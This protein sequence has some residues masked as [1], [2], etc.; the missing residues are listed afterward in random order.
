M[1]TEFDQILQWLWPFAVIKIL[2]Q[3]KSSEWWVEFDHSLHKFLQTYNRVMALDYCQNFVSAQNRVNGLMA[4]DH[5]LHM[6]LPQPDVGW[7]YHVSM[8]Q[9]PS[10]RPK[11][12]KHKQTFDNNQGP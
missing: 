8:R 5:I 2:F 3:L 7:D 11:V 9:I 12:I 4:F 10:I 1:L 6:H